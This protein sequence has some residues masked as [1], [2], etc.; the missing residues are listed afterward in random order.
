MGLS[1]ALAPGLAPVVKGDAVMLTRVV[2]NLVSNALFY[3]A[4]A[5]VAVALVDGA[6]VIDVEDDGPG[7]SEADLERVFDP[8]YRGEQSR[9]ASTGGAGLGLALVRSL[10]RAHGGAVVLKKR[11]AGGLLARVT[12]PTQPVS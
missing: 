7:L 8:F 6:A 10:V 2:R 4:R 11:A 9:N 1:W 12:L 3:G 5:R